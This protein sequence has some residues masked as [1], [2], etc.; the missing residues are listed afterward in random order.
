MNDYDDPEPEPDE[1]LELFPP[2]SD[3]GPGVRKT[4]GESA[5]ETKMREAF[6]Q[7]RYFE[8]VKASSPLLVGHGPVG[9]L[10]RELPVLGGKFRLDFAIIDAA[11]D[12]FVAV[13][14][15][16]HEFHERT[17]EQAQHDKARDRALT[18]DGWRVLRFTGS[19][20]WADPQARVRE[21]VSMLL[22]DSKQRVG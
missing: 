15:D 14:C 22:T 8:P 6:L 20:V 9:L 10:L 12:T 19:E 11:T 7:S 3:T 1:L 17:K 2:E 13:E 18:A 5:I 16:G 4:C 21:I